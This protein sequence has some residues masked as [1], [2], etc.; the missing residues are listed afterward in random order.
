MF[1]LLVNRHRVCMELLE[2][3]LAI[4]RSPTALLNQ[5][6]LV[7]FVLQDFQN[8][9][10]MEQIVTQQYQIAKPKPNQLVLLVLKDSGWAQMPVLHVQK[11]I[12]KPVTQMTFAHP[13]QLDGRQSQ[14]NALRT[15]QNAQ[16]VNG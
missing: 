3:A 14:E 9:E 13:A 6:Q 16:Q 10:V 12:V 4:Q 11:L 8:M 1:V 5:A 2:T 7:Q 15:S